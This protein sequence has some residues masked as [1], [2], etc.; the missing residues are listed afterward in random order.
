[1]TIEMLV[2]LLAKFPADMIVEFGKADK[3]NF[4]MYDTDEIMLRVGESLCGEHE[5]LGIILMPYVE[6]KETNLCE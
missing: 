1:M 4:V 3:R 2:K 5:F 6:K